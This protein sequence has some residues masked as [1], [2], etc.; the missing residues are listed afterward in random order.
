MC[1]CVCV[2]VYNVRSEE[3]VVCKN[4]TAELHHLFVDKL[5][6]D[7]TFA[8]ALCETTF[9]P[10]LRTV[11]LLFFSVYDKYETFHDLT[12]ISASLD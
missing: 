1:V 7:L 10:T 2:C 12:T 6:N 5:E 3:N 9:T 8:H 11:A 4:F